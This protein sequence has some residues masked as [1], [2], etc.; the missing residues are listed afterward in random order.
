MRAVKYY[1]PKTKK[2][3]IMLV[4]NRGEYGS[5]WSQNMVNPITI[6]DPTVI[7]DLNFEELK[8]EIKSVFKMWVWMTF[9]KRETYNPNQTSEDI[10]NLFRR[11]FGV[12]I[13]ENQVKD[14]LYQ[15]GYKASCMTK[16][17]WHFNIRD[18]RDPG[19]CPADA[20][21]LMDTLQDI[22]RR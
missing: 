4:P 3:E 16:R 9:E 11:I 2:T 21:F 1:S 19:V 18:L 20:R 15:F 10:T 6:V 7:D 12:Y 13:S 17:H 22:E 14:A 8:P 5:A